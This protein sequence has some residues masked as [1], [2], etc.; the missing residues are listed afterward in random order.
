MADVPEFYSDGLEIS[1]TMPWTVALTFSLKDTSQER[2]AKPQVIVRMSPEQAKVNAMLLKRMLKQYEHE[3]N[4]S[5]NLPSSI[6]TQ[7]NLD[8]EN[9]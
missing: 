7:L 4:T 5:I 1:L 6:Y 8:E 3:S 2:K 9:W